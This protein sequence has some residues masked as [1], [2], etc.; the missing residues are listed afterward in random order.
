MDQHL[1]SVGPGLSYETFI[2]PMRFALA[3]NFHRR[4]SDPDL[5]LRFSIGFPF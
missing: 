3:W 5:Y 4:H 2:G 1:L